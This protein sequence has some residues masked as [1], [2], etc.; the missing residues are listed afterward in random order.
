MYQVSSSTELE[1]GHKK[2]AQKAELV[3]KLRLIWQSS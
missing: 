1:Q 3:T 2:T